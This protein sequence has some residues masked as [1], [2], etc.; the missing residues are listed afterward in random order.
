MVIEKLMRIIK[1]KLSKIGNE[2]RNHGCLKIV[3]TSLFE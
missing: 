1:E 3:A 2:N